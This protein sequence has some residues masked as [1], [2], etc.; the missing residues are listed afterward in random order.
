MNNTSFSIAARQQ[1]VREERQYCLPL[2]GPQPQRRGSAN[3]TRCAGSFNRDKDRD[4]DKSIINE[5]MGSDDADGD[6]VNDAGSG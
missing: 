3:T 4:K 1:L 2:E 6:R 5:Y